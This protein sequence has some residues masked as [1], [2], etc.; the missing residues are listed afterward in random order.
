MP[1]KLLDNEELLAVIKDGYILSRI[2]GNR[3]KQG[4]LKKV[5]R[6]YKVDNVVKV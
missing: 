3:L 6:L 2:K 5:R 4:F 1:I